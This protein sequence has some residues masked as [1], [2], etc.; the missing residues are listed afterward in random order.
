VIV[1]D[2]RA[3]ITRRAKDPEKG[4][5]D[6]PGGFLHAG[7]DVIDGLRRE[8]REELGIE[9]DVGLGD[10]VQMVPHTYGDEGDFVLAMGFLA[11]LRSGEPVA[12]DDVAELRWVSLDEVDHVEFAWEHDRTLVRRALE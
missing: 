12:A 4:R 1:S 5:F 10:L 11:R 2:G 8:I 9:I 7:E 6:I 3:L